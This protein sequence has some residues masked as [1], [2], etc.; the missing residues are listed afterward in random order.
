M[1]SCSRFSG[2]NTSGCQVQPIPLLSGK[3]YLPRRNNLHQAFLIRRSC[4]YLH[5]GRM[6]QNPGSGYRGLNYPVFFPKKA[7]FPIQFQILLAV[8]KRPCQFGIWKGDQV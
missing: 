3:G 6:P 4:D 5:S 7:R 1:Q 2:Q 8:K